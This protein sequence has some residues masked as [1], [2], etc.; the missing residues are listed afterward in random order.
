MLF[1]EKLRELRQSKG[2]SQKEVAEKIGINRRSYIAYEQGH[3]YPRHREIYDQLAE[4]F[5]VDKNYLLNEDEEFIAQARM[6]YGSRGS[7]QA[8]EVIKDVTGLFA[9]GEIEEEDMDNIMRAIQEAY[10]EAKER[11]KKY[12]PKTYR[13]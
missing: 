4:I 12:T 5:N 1:G 9:G 13:E 10:W 3:S 8:K 6:K 2:L 11:N 7:K